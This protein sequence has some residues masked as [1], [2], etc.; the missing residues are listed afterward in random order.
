MRSGSC[1]PRR[2]GQADQASPPS[3]S[4]TRCARGVDPQDRREVERDRAD[5]L[6]NASDFWLTTQLAD[7]RD[8]DGELDS[9]KIGERVDQPCP[10]GRTGAD[11]RARR[12]TSLGRRKPIQKPKTIG[13]AFKNALHGR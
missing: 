11:R 3:R 9:E 8:E 12:R 5:R 7:L 6:Q 1:A 4:A 10:R 13:E 2:S